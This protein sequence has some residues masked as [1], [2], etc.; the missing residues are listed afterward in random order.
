MGSGGFVTMAVD[1]FWEQ[2]QKHSAQKIKDEG[3]WVCLADENWKPICDMP[4]L[5]DCNARSVRLSASDIELS[6][7]ASSNGIPHMVVDELIAENLGVFSERGTIEPNM[8]AAR[9]IIVQT[10]G[11]RSRQAYFISHTLASGRG[12]VP[13]TIAPSGQDLIGLLDVTPCP[14]VPRKWGKEPMK[15]WEQ[16]AGGR[17]SK[18]RFYGAVEMADSLDGYTMNGPAV[19]VIKTLVQ[20]SVDALCRQMGWDKPHIV[21]DWSTSD[22]SDEIFIRLSDQTVWGA[23]AD[24]ARISGVTVTTWLWFPGD[25]PILVRPAYKQEPVLRSFDHPICVVRVEKSREIE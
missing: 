17:Y 8:S 11:S 25:D 23:I 13:E 9:N 21:V 10:A 14:S 3:R 12:D 19:Q 15:W 6:T 5:I 18:P 7:P 20:D 16:D 22:E 2:V 24:P 1:K 4:T